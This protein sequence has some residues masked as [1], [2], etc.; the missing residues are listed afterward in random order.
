MKKILLIA[1]AALVSLSLAACGRD[2][3]AYE[4]DPLLTSY[5]AG[6]ASPAYRMLQKNIFKN[7]IENGWAGDDVE[8]AAWNYDTFAEYLCYDAQGALIEPP[9]P[10]YCCTYS[11][12]GGETGFV[13]VSYSGEALT[14]V[15]SAQTPSLFDLRACWDEVA[16]LLSQSDVDLSTA[17]AARVSLLNAAGE[18]YEA[19]QITD[20]GGNACVYEFP[21]V[22]SQQ[23]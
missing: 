7:M 21:S 13:V 11:A 23:N 18:E 14:R 16:D 4:N 20:G 8:G 2:G 15:L 9:E 3:K 5:Y 1:L 17:T 12:S 19:I 6:Q 10:L 22:I